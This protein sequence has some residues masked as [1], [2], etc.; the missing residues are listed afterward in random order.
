MLYFA[1]TIIRP[2]HEHINRVSDLAELE[3]ILEMLDLPGLTPPHWIISDIEAHRFEGSGKWE[4]Q[5]NP[6][7]W[8]LIW[9]LVNDNQPSRS[10]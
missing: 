9:A 5:G 2:G 7:S 3:Y 4:H 10:L 8:T 1:W 6:Y